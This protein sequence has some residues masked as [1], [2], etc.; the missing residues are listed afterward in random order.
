MLNILHL[1]FVYDILTLSRASISE[2]KVIQGI[3][4][5]FC[6]AS[7]MIINAQKSII[8]NSDV[9]TDTLNAIKDVL[10]FLSKDLE[11]GCNYLFFF[12]F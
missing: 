6:K 2:W 4:Q 3:L 11:L 1:L 9:N 10:T 8:L 5:D 7:G 12:V